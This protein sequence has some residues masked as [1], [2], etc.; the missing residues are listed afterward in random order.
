MYTKHK[1]KYN[2]CCFFLRQTRLEETLKTQTTH[3]TSTDIY[4]YI[5]LLYFFSLAL[6]GLMHGGMLNSVLSKVKVY[7]FCSPFVVEKLTLDFFF[8]SYSSSK[9]YI[10]F[11]N[12]SDFFRDHITPHNIMKNKSFSF[13]RKFFGFLTWIF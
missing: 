5:L 11:C 10:W 12:V 2:F 13:V 7:N 8:L 3:M 4:I 9:F 6:F 1:I